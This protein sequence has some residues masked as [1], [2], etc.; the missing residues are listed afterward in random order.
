MLKLETFN[1]L[2]FPE[3]VV[4]KEE[5]TINAAGQIVNSNRVDRSSLQGARR[6]ER[7]LHH[8]P[9]CSTTQGSA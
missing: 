1:I 7:S 6:E 4:S 8:A 3:N 9:T 2:D 5:N